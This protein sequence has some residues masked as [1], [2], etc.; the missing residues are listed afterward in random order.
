[1]SPA[2]RATLLL[3]ATT[4]LWGSSFFTMSWGTRGIAL[5]LGSGAAPSAFLFL[6]FLASA[7][8]QVAIF[9]SLL[10]DLTGPLVRAGVT[11]SLPFYAGFFLQAT[12]LVSSTS[13]VVAFLTSLF[14]VI[15]PLVGRLFFREIVAS[16][17]LVGAFISLG[18][19]YVM[20]DPSVGLGRGEL[21]SIACA[22]AFAF[23][24]QMT[25]VVTRHHRPEAISFVQF[26][27]AVIYSGITLAA[28]GVNPG[29]LLRSLGERHVA[30]TVL[31]GAA[32]CSVIAMG[33]LNRYQREISATRA[34][35]I[36]MIEPVFAAL[37]AALLAGESMTARKI[38]G[39][40]VILIGNLAC[41]LMGRQTPEEKMA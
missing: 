33:V 21:L 12:G 24:I 10:K 9:P 15:T 20:T 31:Y 41:E 19:V 28:L 3:L 4:V 14:V 26:C 5:H 29:N 6:R 37:F 30:W 16:S 27:C 18:G 38:L 11:L 36:Y 35:V 39:G 23:Q 32:A 1:M 17:T 34:S 7:V 40:A 2:R 13:T 25:N 22:V 8:I